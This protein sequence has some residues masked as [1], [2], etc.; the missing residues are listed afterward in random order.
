[1]DATDIK[2]NNLWRNAIISYTA[3]SVMANKQDTLYKEGC[4]FCDIVS[5]KA[6]S[7]TVFEDKISLAFLDHSP[8][9]KGHVILIPKAHYET[10]YD[11]PDETLAG[12]FATARKISKGIEI[13]LGAEGT[14][15]AV[16]NKVSQ[17]VPHFHIHIVPRRHGD[18]LHGFFWPRQKYENEEEEEEVRREIEKAIDGLKEE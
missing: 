6:S 8:L 18:G 9:F 12:L 13:A 5:G 3:N 16:N 2:F 10:I 17:S 14:F 7:Y 11:V 4:T 1:M 15:V